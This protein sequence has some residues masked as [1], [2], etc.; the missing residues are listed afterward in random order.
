MMPG[1]L[2]HAEDAEVA[3]ADVDAPQDGLGK[4]KG[5]QKLLTEVQGTFHYAQQSASA[6]AENSHS[7]YH[8]PVGFFAPGLMA[9]VVL[10]Q[11]RLWTE[12]EGAAIQQAH[13]VT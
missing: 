4:E 12:Q 1:G 3:I 10:H 7:P 11:F 8:H 6:E 5:R 9:T 2:R 13:R